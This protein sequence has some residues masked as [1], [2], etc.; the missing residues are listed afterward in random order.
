MDKGAK[1]LAPYIDK[2]RNVGIIIVPPL[3]AELERRLGRSVMPSTVYRLLLRH[4]W[5]KL[6][7]NKQHPK[8]AR[9]LIGKIYLA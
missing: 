4:V 2:A 6:S 7:P 5:R 3:Q 1:F 9:S 8:A